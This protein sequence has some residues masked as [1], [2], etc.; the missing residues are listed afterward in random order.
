MHQHENLVDHMAWI[1]KYYG[2]RRWFFRTQIRFRDLLV[3]FFSRRSRNFDC[4]S[5]CDVLFIKRFSTNAIFE[6][7]IERFEPAVSAGQIQAEG[8]TEWIAKR[9]LIFDGD[10]PLSL[11]MYRARAEYLIR[12]FNPKVI[13][14]THNGSIFSPILKSAASSRGISVVHLA[15]SVPTPNY[16]HF[17]MIDFD[18]YVAYGESSYKLLQQQERIYGDTRFVYAGSCHIQERLRAKEM[19]DPGGSTMTFVLLGSGP[20]VEKESQTEAI[21]S[22]AIAAASKFQDATLLFKPHPR[23]DRQ[24]WTRLVQSKPE[25]RC[26]VIESLPQA[27][28]ASIALCGYTNAIIDVT[29]LGMVP[30]LVCAKIEADYFYYSEF[31]GTPVFSEKQLLARIRDINDRRAFY[32]A[33]SEKFSSFHLS[34]VGDSVAYVAR[35]LCDLAKGNSVEEHISVPGFARESP[36]ASAY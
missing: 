32:E 12:R 4:V 10:A 5:E 18:Y 1:R 2:L 35:F 31:F 30:I 25:L 33:Q 17:S 19:P 14:T 15:H 8:P 7:L 6:K 27:P 16:R 22:T 9:E 29:V 36:S 20:N 34:A 26:R 21:Y 23:S 11:R 3:V 28:R 24:L 13:V